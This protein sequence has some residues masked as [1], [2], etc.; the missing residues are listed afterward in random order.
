MSNKWKLISTK[1]ETNYNIE[2]I[3]ETKPT[4][5]RKKKQLFFFK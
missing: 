2:N 3:P 5:L 4:L 1:I